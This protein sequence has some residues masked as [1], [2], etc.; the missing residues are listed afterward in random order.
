VECIVVRTACICV[1]VCVC[2]CVCADSLPLDTA[3]DKDFAPSH[4][5]TN[6][7]LEMYYVMIKTLR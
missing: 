3:V 2:V 6:R 1:C 4:V 5:I 7:A